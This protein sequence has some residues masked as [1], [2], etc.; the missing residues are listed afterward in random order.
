MS[1]KKQAPKRVTGVTPRGVF[2][3][4]NLIKPDYGTDEYP[5][6]GGEYNV[7]LRMSVADAQPMID[8]LQVE[9]DKAVQDAEQKF[10]A[11]PV[12]TRKK[13]KEVTVNDF[14]QEVFDK[15]TEEP[16]G[17]VEFRFKMTASGTNKKGEAWERKPALFD[18]KGQPLTKLKAI[19]GGTIGKVSYS[20]GPYFVGGTGAAGISLYLE[21]AQIIELRQGGARSA[22][23]YGFGAEEDG[24]D[25]TEDSHGFGDESE[26]SEGDDTQDGAD[27]PEDF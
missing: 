2:V 14:Y 15:E 12:A 21:A 7:R 9:L 8:K 13:L 17:E 10:A 6:E 27:G 26:G 19:Y 23:G 4:P 25:S 18:A 1:N 22:S 11:L 16:T 3:F 24:Y 5:K 20:V